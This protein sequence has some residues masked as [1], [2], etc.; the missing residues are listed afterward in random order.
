[1][2]AYNRITL[3]PQL[4]GV[5]KTS[6]MVAACHAVAERMAQA[7]LSSAPVKTGAYKS[8]IKVVDEIHTDRAAAR[9]YATDR[10]S[11]IIEARTRNLGRA[12]DAGRS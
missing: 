2:V 5:L 8:G 11:Q 6:E 9:V 1:M 3:A 10:K 12:F 7:A 4:G